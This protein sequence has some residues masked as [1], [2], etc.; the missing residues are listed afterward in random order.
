MSAHYID[1]LCNS[2]AP[3]KAAL[4][5]QAISAQEIP[6]KVKSD[7]ENGFCDA[8]AMVARLDRLGFETALL[9]VSHARTKTSATVEFEDVISSLDEVRDLD[10]RFRSRFGALWVIDPRAGS[11]AV[12]EAE[13]VLLNPFVMG[14]YLHVHSFDKPFDH[15]D[16][17]P[18]YDLAAR[19]GVPVVMQAGGSGG[20]MPSQCGA[21]IGIDRPAIY[22][23]ETT[24]VLSHTGWPWVDEAI[25]MAEKFHNVYLGTAS[26]PPNRWSANLVSFLRHGGKKK[27]LFGTNFPTVGHAQALERL[28]ELGLTDAVRE[29]LL[30]ANARRIFTRLSPSNK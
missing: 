22:F 21:P 24:F 4:W 12:R 9:P 15:A 19:V 8:T 14:M 20:R 17:Y 10:A 2:F 26:W 30:S 3:E 7:T 5:G 1:Y 28:G 23:E 6:L 29:G 13:E 27:V 11:K 16:F 18:F 25:A